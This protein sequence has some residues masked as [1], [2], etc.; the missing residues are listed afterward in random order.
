M[1]LL[2]KASARNYLPIVPSREG[3]RRPTPRTRPLH[4][5]PSPLPSGTPS[6]MPTFSR[7]CWRRPSAG[8][9]TGLYTRLF[10]SLWPGR[11]GQRHR[12]A[13]GS[14]RVRPRPRAPQA[15]KYRDIKT[16]TASEYLLAA[17]C[18]LTEHRLSWIDAALPV[19]LGLSRG[20]FYPPLR[21]HLRRCPRSRPP[22]PP[23][24]RF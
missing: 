23:A 14:P 6:T 3:N 12:G 1:S 11:P 19:Y 20:P 4:P 18:R 15:A 24:R 10:K 21:L 13:R 7:P 5:H 16:V 9:R 8:G 2:E 22:A 17:P